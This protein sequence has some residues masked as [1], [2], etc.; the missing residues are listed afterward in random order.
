MRRVS[1]PSS[2]LFLAAVLLA[3]PAS[4][5]SREPAAQVP[6]AGAEELLAEGVDRSEGEEEEIREREEW[7]ADSRGLKDVARPDRLRAEAVRELAVRR[8]ARSEELRAGSQVW[9]TVGPTSMTMLSWAM[10]PVAGRIV[11]LAVHPTDEAIA[12]VGSASGGLWKTVDG[13]S[14][15]TS[16]FDE[17]GTLS[18]G[19]VVLDPGN[20][21]V[22]WA[23]TGE[24]QSTCS[25]YMGMG[26]FRSADGGAT[27]EARNGT[28]PNAL[29]L[30]Y[31]NSIAVHPSSPDTLLVAGE[32]FCLPD[33]TRVGGGV[34]KTTDGGLNWTRVRA[35]TGSDVIYDPGQPERRLPGHERPRASSSP[36]TAATPGR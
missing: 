9:Q 28:A 14:V 16:L 31:V 32:A 2:V 18:I 23:G 6:D 21:D 33:G 34:F 15:W 27:F 29:E 35:G 19:A 30:S 24:R 1:L 20:P 8:A 7:F 3:T 36:S 22:V 26:L 4:A 13:G 25:N 11:S 10:G 17:V 12:Y 5:Q